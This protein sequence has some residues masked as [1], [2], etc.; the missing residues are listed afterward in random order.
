MGGKGVGREWDESGK[1]RCGKLRNL[2]PVANVAFRKVGIN[3][4][5]SRLADTYYYVLAW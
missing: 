2:V 5:P 4:E 1:G 3:V